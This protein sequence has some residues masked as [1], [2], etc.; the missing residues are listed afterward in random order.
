[1]MQALDDQDYFAAVRST[2]R[3]DAPVHWHQ[4]IGEFLGRATLDDGVH[5][6]L[7][8]LPIDIL[9]RKR[10]GRPLIFSFHGNTPRNPDLKLPVFTGLNVTR[11]LDASFVAFS[12]PSLYLDPDL[13]LAWFAGARGLDLQ[14]QLPSV[15]SKLVDDAAATDVMFFGGS[16]G[17]FAS[18]YYSAL[19]PGSLALV[20]NP[21]TDITRY[22]PP[23]VAEYGR[24]AFGFADYEQARTGLPSMVNSG[25]GRLYAAGY[26]NRVVYLQNN[27][28][29]HVQTHL[30]PLLESIG[31]ATSTV[32]KGASVS[33]EIARDFW[34]HL[35]DWGEGHVPPPPAVLA[36]L[37]A[38]FAD[39]PR[40]WRSGFA[41]D[42]MTTILEA[43]FA[44][45]S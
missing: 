32:T 24:I 43:G 14:P 7:G 19:L 45:K 9:V 4:S 31:A 41:P 40:S 30:L 22:N 12:D 3:W 36:A 21:Q 17:G 26:G 1:M 25:L 2:S 23:H 35:A 44:A 37:L 20:W 34:L 29:G 42:R 33:A 39:D 28:D 11:D 16:G 13:K 8:T 10:P 18:L 38:G 27:S 5:T 15:L 6:I